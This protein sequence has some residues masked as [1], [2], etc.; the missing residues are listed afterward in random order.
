MFKLLHKRHDITT[1]YVLNNFFLHHCSYF[2][3]NL[4]L[5]GHFICFFTNVGVTMGF[6]T[7]TIYTT[8]GN[9]NIGVVT[10]PIQLKDNGN[11][12]ICFFGSYRVITPTNGYTS[13][14]LLTMVMVSIFLVC[15]PP[16]TYATSFSGQLFTNSFMGSTMDVDRTIQR[17]M[18]YLQVMVGLFIMMNI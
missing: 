9:N 11:I 4:F 6:L 2:F 14:Q 13:L 7:R 12:T 17:T 16:F 5:L 3:F 8:F 15:T 1:L 10:T 18:T